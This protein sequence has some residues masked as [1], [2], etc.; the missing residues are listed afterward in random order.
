MDIGQ[1]VRYGL[2]VQAFVTVGPEHLEK[3]DESLG[4]L[5]SYLGVARGVHRGD[6]LDRDALRRQAEAG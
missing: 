2:G 6:G 3:I 1:A 5:S 4:S